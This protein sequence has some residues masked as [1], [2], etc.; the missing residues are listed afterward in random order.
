M[1]PELELRRRRDQPK[2]VRPSTPRAVPLRTARVRD[3]RR[4][5]EDEFDSLGAYTPL[6]DA[7][8]SEL[9][10]L[11]LEYLPGPQGFVRWYFDG[12]LGFEVLNSSLGTYS[13]RPG[14]HAT[15]DDAASGH[16]LRPRLIPEEPMYLIIS[17]APA[18]PLPP[19]PHARQS[20][21]R[22]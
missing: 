9:R 8:H 21:S 22:P 16:E 10:S 6:P 11:R 7:V 19:H 20:T 1:V 17:V 18:P 14:R 4:Y 3:L 5:G 12:A 13:E 2:L 15:S